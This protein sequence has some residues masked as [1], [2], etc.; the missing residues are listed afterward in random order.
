[1]KAYRY[2]GAHA[3][4][5]VTGQNPEA[6]DYD[7]PRGDIYGFASYVVASNDYGDTRLLHV[8]TAHLERDALAPAQALAD[9]LTVRLNA[10]GKLPVGFD[11]WQQGRAIYGSDAYMEYGQAEQLQWEQEAA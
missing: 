9:A 1:M 3:D 4:I 11:S 7:N 8:A 10:L 2:F 5:V 6:A